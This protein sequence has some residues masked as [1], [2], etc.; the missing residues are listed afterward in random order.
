MRFDVL[1]LFP[2]LFEAAKVGV[3]GR[4]F[5]ELGHELAALDYRAF[6][7]NP[8][9]HVDDAPFGGGPG[10][11]LRPE[12][13]RDALASLARRPSSRVI[14]FS[15]AAPP[16]DHAKVRELAGL[17]QLLLVCTRFEGLDQRAVDLYVDEELSVGEA[18]LSGGELPALCLIDAVCRWL[19]GVLGNAESAAADSFANGLLDHPHYTRPAAFEGVD[20]PAVLLSGDHEAIRL[21][22]LRESMERT[23]RL[24]PDLWAAFLATRLRLLPRADQW[25][26]WQV[27]HPDLRDRPKPKGWKG[28]P[29]P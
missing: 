16:L 6:A 5:R 19:P 25:C 18:V 24:R 9:G 22:R 20:A 12:V 11:V 21:W 15:P 8:F 2:S 17:D 14:H 13:L 23:R 4:A 7:G 1:T 26:A 27:Q 29:E 28:F 3:T 10:M